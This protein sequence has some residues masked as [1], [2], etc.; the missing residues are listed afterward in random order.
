MERRTSC[1]H[2]SSSQDSGAL[3]MLVVATI[4]LHHDCCGERVSTKTADSA[5]AT[6]DEKAS[7]TGDSTRRLR[8]AL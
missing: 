1:A 7:L 6:K 3:V 8:S 2:E 5:G 4:N